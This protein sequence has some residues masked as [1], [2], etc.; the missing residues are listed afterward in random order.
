MPGLELGL[1]RLVMLKKQVNERFEEAVRRVRV[2]VR[3]G[4]Y[5]LLLHTPFSI[6]GL[7]R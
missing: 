7:A 3:G 2:R 4:D 6:V 5:F 1:G